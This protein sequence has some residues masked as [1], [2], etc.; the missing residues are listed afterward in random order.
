[1]IE[2]Q[3]GVFTAM[4]VDSAKKIFNDKVKELNDRSNHRSLFL[5]NECYDNI[6]WEIKEAQISRKS[7]QPVTSK[8]YQ[9]L[10]RY[11]VMKIGDMQKLIA[12]GSHEND[13]SS[14]TARWRSCCS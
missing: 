5:D 6:L 12:S 4:S 7:N 10:K 8:H 1:M 9:H 3:A 13:D 2:L 11:D 14:I